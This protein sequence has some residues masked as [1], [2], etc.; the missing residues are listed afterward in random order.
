MR[1]L[2]VPSRVLPLAPPLQI[3]RHFVDNWNKYLDIYKQNFMFLSYIFKTFKEVGKSNGNIT[4]NKILF[5]FY[6][7]M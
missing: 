4:K 7:N 3:R 6:T 5:L 2:N 1:G